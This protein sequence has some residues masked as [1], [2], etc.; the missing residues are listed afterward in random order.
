[1]GRPKGS[2]GETKLKLLAVLHSNEKTGDSS[3]G[4]G[5]WKMM[6]QRYRCCLGDDGLRNIYHHLEN[7]H[8]LGFVMRS[9]NHLIEGAPE[10]HLYDLTSKGRELY[11]KYGRYLI[12]DTTNSSQPH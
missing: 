12:Y 2:L 1:M 9:S 4:Y 6:N 3:Y 8:D 7:L 10:R 11:E 5:V